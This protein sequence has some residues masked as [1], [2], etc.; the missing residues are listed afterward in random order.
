[1]SVV[2]LSAVFL[3]WLTLGP[4]CSW[5]IIKWNILEVTSQ[6]GHCR[7]KPGSEGEN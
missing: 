7:V 5:F 1:M 6:R 4:A 2:T 3:E